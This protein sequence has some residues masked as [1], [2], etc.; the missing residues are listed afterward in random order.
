MNVTDMLD[1]A[2]EMPYGAA[3]IALL[4]QAIA[5]AD[6][7]RLTDEAF[8][9]RILATT[10][11]IYGGEPAR[12]FVTFSWCLTEFDQDPVRYGRWT[13]HL[14]W[15]FKAM[16]NAMTKFPE[17]PLART[18]DVLDDMERRWR[19]GGHRPH[20]VYMQR[21]LVARH[22]GDVDAAQD[23]FDRWSTAPRDDLS[24]CDGCDPTGKVYWLARRGQDEEAIALAEPVLAGRLSCTEQPHSI[25][26]ALLLPYLRTGRTDAARD[27]HRRAY[28]THRTRLADLADIAEHVRF[29]ALTG[30]D[31]LGLE[32][33]ERHLDWLD[34]S[35]TPWATMT[36]AASAALVLRR[37]DAAGHRGL[38]VG[39]RPA[40]AV[41]EDLAT[42]ALDL[43]AR[44]DARNGTGEHTGQTRETLATTPIGAG[45]SLAAP[46]SRRAQPASSDTHT[47]SGG[48]AGG[49]DRPVWT[50]PAPPVPE[51]AGPD[52][53]LDLAE[54]AYRERR[55]AEAF[56]A[57]R[58][59]DDRYAGGPLTD[60]QRARHLDGLGSRVAHDDDHAAAEEAWQRAGA[61]Y[62]DAGDEV[63]RQIARGRLGMGLLRQGRADEGRALIEESTAYLVA[64]GAP[65]QL[66][67]AHLRL[68]YAQATTGRIAES[69]ATSRAA[70]EH[71][72]A[73]EDPSVLGQIL[74]LRAQALGRLGEIEAAAAAAGESRR[75]QR[76]GGPPEDLAHACLL[77]GVALRRLGQA[78]EALAAF[79][80]A[81]ALPCGA[82]LRRMVGRQRAGLLA[83]SARAAEA[84]TPLAEEIA[85]L[86]A[87][88][89][90]DTVPHTQ[91][92][93]AIAY[94]NA[95]RPL[96]AAE[97]AE[98]ALAAFEAAGDDQALG[99]RD[100]LVAVYQELAEH[101]PMLTQLTALAAAIAALDD[102]AALG[103]VTERLAEALDKL[104]R[105][106]T[107]AA[108]F[109]EAATAYLNA[110]RPIDAA[111]TSR[112]HATSLL[113][114]GQPE[115]A[116]AALAA[117]DTA[118]AALPAEPHAVWERAMLDYDG[119]RLLDRTDRAEE[120]IPRA[121]RAVAGF[122]ELGAGAQAGFAG[123]L[124]GELLRA[125]GRHEAAETAL[126]DALALVPD[127]EQALRGQLEGA[128]SAARDDRF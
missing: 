34:R 98:E 104:D 80:E 44:F 58:A 79:D 113:W 83:N 90:R 20:A 51:T 120:A 57:W 33:V 28:R 37:L 19:A 36:F 15:S 61:L 5:H 69:V 93:L 43:A 4:E 67:R 109:A 6:A 49:E 31:A 128:L 99:V 53:L 62:A 111:R 91:Q 70:E 21:H 42:R 95:G 50:E 100:L 16:V 17:I 39:G 18:A 13:H 107:A 64:H 41:A 117:A 86:T 75:R 84:I 26:T 65:G 127:D 9:A 121:A 72:P 74:A 97:V 54:A 101:E 92:E 11:Y 12:S 78:D 103:R 25:H 105:D 89:D 47:D 85:A 87:A 7:Q 30:N 32:I 27:A 45:F 118:A 125:A 115:Q 73:A 14:L 68:A 112:R 23:W 2:R 126:S 77:H 102:P 114:A 24:D 52:E 10:G 124:H 29:C 63:R 48:A 60:L 46:G 88:G 22:V 82:E 76:A 123:L 8:E 96:D 122:R 3:Q 35:P 116:L 110:G 106:A 56:A 71:A 1:Q 55:E 108:R 66:A 59:F 94:L 119:A 40:G 81:L 38:T